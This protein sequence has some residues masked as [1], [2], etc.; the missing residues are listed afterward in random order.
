M[1]MWQLNEDSVCSHSQSCPPNSTPRISSEAI[2]PILQK[3]MFS[4]P[5]LRMH[6]EK[7]QYQYGIKVALRT[8]CKAM[9]SVKGLHK[10]LQN[11]E[12]QS[13]GELLHGK[14]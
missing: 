1:G 4:A 13:V 12:L 8:I 14:E 11:Q 3:E 2:E 6:A 10:S 7:I 5:P 9:R